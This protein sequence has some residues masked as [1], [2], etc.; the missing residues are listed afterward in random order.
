MSEIRDFGKLIGTYHILGI[1]KINIV[2]SFISLQITLDLFELIL[3]HIED[4][5]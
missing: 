3:G 2:V 5:I 4:L 1:Y